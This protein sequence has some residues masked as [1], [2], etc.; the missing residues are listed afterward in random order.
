MRLY[1]VNKW[2]LCNSNKSHK[3]SH[4]IVEY[5]FEQGEYGKF[6]ILNL[7]RYTF[8]EL[9]VWIE[10]PIWASTQKK[11]I[12]Q[13]MPLREEKGILAALKKNTVKEHVRFSDQIK[14]KVK[15]LK[16]LQ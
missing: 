1:S 6:P 15:N 11:D 2:E 8:N 12:T 9:F 3:R 10:N 16:P 7:Y 14:S 4:K 5:N 13:S